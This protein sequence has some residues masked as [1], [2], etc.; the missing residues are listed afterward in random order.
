MVKDSKSIPEDSTMDDLNYANY[1]PYVDFISFDRRM[2]HYIM[3]TCVNE[4][5]GHERGIY[6][7]LSEIFAVL[8]KRKE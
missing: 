2:Y 5:L 4:K 3:H 7:N 6:K 8:E 1:I